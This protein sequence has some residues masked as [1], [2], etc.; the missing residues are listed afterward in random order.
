MFKQLEVCKT[1]ASVFS[2][3]AARRQNLD[4]RNCVVLCLFVFVQQQ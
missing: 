4:I 1:I 2:L 3:V